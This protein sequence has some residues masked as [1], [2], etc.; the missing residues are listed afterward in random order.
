MGF[1]DRMKKTAA[2]TKLR[3]EMVLIDQKIASRKKI[4]GV[5]LYNVLADWES[6]HKDQEPPIKGIQLILKAARE[7]IFELFK[8]RHANDEQLDDIEFQKEQTE[9][10]ASAKDKAK[11]AGRWISRTGTATK[12]KA[13]IAYYDREMR[14]RK[15]IFGVLSFDELDLASQEI[16]KVMADVVADD[17]EMSPNNTESEDVLAVVERC[18]MDVGELLTKK[19][20]KQATIEAL[21]SPSPDAGIEEQPLTKTDVDNAEIPP[22]NTESE[23]VLAAVERKT[24][25]GELP[26]KKEEKQA[27]IEDAGMEE[28]PLTESPFLTEEILL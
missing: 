21:S 26:T 20:E 12:L 11:N 25:V 15:E 9:T 1:L 3:G 23:D 7:D 2:K 6:N 18:K 4:F 17:V 24:D 22:T 16:N 14:L 28:Q 13:Q 27:T 19:K 5:D 8:K 10:A